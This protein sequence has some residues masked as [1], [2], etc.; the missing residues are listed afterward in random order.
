MSS[1]V[2]EKSLVRA[3]RY[4]SA[5]LGYKPLRSPLFRHYQLFGV[6]VLKILD[7]VLLQRLL[8]YKAAFLWPTTRIIRAILSFTGDRYHRLC[9]LLFL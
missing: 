2:G 9:C 1:R 4:E 6:K 8:S 5:V 3:L 7:K